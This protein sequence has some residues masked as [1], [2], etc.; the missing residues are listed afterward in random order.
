MTETN[1]EAG[2][3]MTAGQMLKEAR[4]AGRRK[5][6]LPTLPEYA[7]ISVFCDGFILS[8][9]ELHSCLSAADPRRSWTYVENKLGENQYWTMSPTN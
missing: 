9:D 6:E 5:R 3:E 2:Q 8:E 1:I 4:T 7:V